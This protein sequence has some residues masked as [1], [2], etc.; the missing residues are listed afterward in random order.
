MLVPLCC[1]S[2]MYVAWI[3]RLPLFVCSFCFFMIVEKV[4]CYGNDSCE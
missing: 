3:V 4:L 2:I 1:K